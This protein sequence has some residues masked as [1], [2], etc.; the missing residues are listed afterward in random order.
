MNTKMPDTNELQGH[1]RGLIAYA[2]LNNR[3]DLIAILRSNGANIQNPTD[4]ELITAVFVALRKSKSFRNDLKNLLSGISASQLG[5]NSTAPKSDFTG[6]INPDSISD[7]V[8]GGTNPK[9]GFS[10]FVSAADLNEMAAS[11]QPSATP[12]QVSPISATPSTSKKPFAD[13]TFGSFLNNLFSKENV[14]KA[15]GTGLDMLNSKMAANANQQQL[16]AATKLQVAKTEAEIAAQRNKSTTP[17]WLIPVIIGSAVL[18]V[19]GIVIY[20]ALK[21]KKS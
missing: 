5:M 6:S 12:S 18:I 8:K 3:K 4:R 17:A 7:F 2:V 16:D 20:T 13:T 10:G 11:S 21:K 14:D 15:V 1:M 19:G 9:S